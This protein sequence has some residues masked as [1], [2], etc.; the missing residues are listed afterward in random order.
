M[1]KLLIIIC[2]V[3]LAYSNQGNA[4][5]VSAFSV[6]WNISHTM[7]PLSNLNN[8]LFLFNQNNP[9]LAKPYTMSD[10]LQGLYV[11]WRFGSPNGGM[12]L[13]WQN[14]HVFAKEEGIA[15]AEGETEYSIHRIKVRLNML[16]WGYYIS[17]YKRIKMGITFDFGSFKVLE[18]TGTEASFD[19]AGYETF[20]DKKGTGAYGITANISAPIPFNQHLQL[21][22]QPYIQFVALPVAMTVTD[23]N[24]NQSKRYFNPSNFG[25]SIF[26]S[27][28][29]GH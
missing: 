26:L 19:N 21:R 12:I 23:N 28:I 2:I 17:L 1:K 14:K 22:F 4:Q 24:S 7:K 25:I 10:F 29:G 8:Y 6:G 5:A 3:M 27:F 13:G 11:D 20:Y 16:S 15:T 9:G 18:K